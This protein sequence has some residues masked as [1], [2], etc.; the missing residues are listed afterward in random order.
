MTEKAKEST[1][2]IVGV[3]EVAP[4]RIELMVEEAVEQTEAGF[5]VHRADVKLD[6]ETES[7]QT[8]AQGRASVC[9]Y[10]NDNFTEFEGT[11]QLTGYESSHTPLGLDHLKLS[12]EMTEVV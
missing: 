11:F 10:I 2:E 12:F 9:G 6:P 4:D 8:V 5:D 1:S 7:L 3:A